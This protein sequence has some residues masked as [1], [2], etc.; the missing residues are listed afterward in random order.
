[1]SRQPNTR[2]VCKSSFSQIGLSS[3][4]VS[5]RGTFASG[6]ISVQAIPSPTGFACF[7]SAPVGASCPSPSLLRLARSY[8]APLCSFITRWTPGH[9]TRRGLPAFLSFRR[10]VAR[11]LTQR[12]VSEAAAHGFLTLYLFTPSAEA[13][14]FHLG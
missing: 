5:R 2:A 4:L 6:H 11:T 12:A 13:F 14:F 1:M 10:G 3:C 7:V 9:N 8:S